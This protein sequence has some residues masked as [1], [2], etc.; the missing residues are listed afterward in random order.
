MKTTSFL[1]LAALLATSCHRPELP[2]YHVNGMFFRKGA[3]LQ[4]IK[5]NRGTTLSDLDGNHVMDFVPGKEITTIPDEVLKYRIPDKYVKNREQFLD[6][7]EAFDK[8]F[9]LQVASALDLD[10]PRTLKL[11]QPL[12]GDFSLQDLDGTEWNKARLMGHVT[13]IN[14]WFSS[15]PPCLR[16]MPILSSWKDQFPQVTFL[17]ANFEKP[18]VVKRVVEARK[19]SWTHL[20]DDNY[21][22]QYLDGEGFPMFLVLDSHGLVRFVRN[23]SSEEIHAEVLAMIRQ[24]LEE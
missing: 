23:G 3:P 21:F 13:V 20:C 11:G 9:K 16:E 10:R 8:L 18:G 22:G 4:L 7:K 12:P 5:S 24:L 19:F 1:L 14:L 17:S 2:A 15:C 6:N